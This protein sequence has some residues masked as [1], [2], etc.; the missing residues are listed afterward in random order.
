M[1]QWETGRNQPEAEVLPKLARLLQVSI[2][3]LLADPTPQPNG[4]PAG[5]GAP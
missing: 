1:A 2:E 4:E 3:D 5:T